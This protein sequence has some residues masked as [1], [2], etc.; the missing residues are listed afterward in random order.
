MLDIDW[1]VVIAF[2]LGLAALYGIGWLLVV[3]FR[4]V[5]K[6]VG[7]ALL[8]G[9]LLWALSAFGAPIH[10]SVALNPLNALV[11]GLL[12]VPGVALLVLISWL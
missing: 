12:G 10:I 3:P 2:V 7:N 8:G 6:F 9:I 4:W 5:L 11:A 1:G